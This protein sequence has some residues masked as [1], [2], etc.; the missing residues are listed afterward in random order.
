MIKKIV[1]GLNKLH[2]KLRE[3]NKSHSRS[4]DWDKIRDAHISLHPAC[5]ACGG[6]ENLQVHHIVPYHVEASRELD[7]SNLITLCMGK[8]DC[9]LHVGHGGSFRFY[10]PSVVSDALLYSASFFKR[11]DR[12]VAEIKK[13]RQR[14]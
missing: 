12:L 7:P 13:R 10:N 8:H 5:A 1:S 2:S 4:P 9:H 6:S 11:R 3:K 14:S